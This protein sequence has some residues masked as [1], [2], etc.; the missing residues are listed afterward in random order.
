LAGFRVRFEPEDGALSEIALA[1]VSVGA[2][3]V[4]DHVVICKPGDVF[5]LKDGQWFLIRNNETTLIEG[6]WDRIED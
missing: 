5:E 6:K 1:P 3:Y 2:K 4:L